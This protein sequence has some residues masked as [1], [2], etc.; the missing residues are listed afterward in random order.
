MLLQKCLYAAF[1]RVTMETL[2]TLLSET[3]SSTC[4]LPSSPYPRALLLHLSSLSCF[5]S[6]SPFLVHSHQH[7]K[8]A[9]T[10]PTL[11][12]SFSGFHMPYQHTPSILCSLF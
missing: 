3:N 8:N 7:K 10:C 12:K 6:F 4:T 11:K 2:F 5:I 1:P 9:V